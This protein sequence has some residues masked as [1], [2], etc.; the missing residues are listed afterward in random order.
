MNAEARA[1]I[2]LISLRFLITFNTL[3]AETVHINVYKYA[4]IYFSL[5]KHF[6]EIVRNKY[7]NEH[8]YTC[9][10]YKN[11]YIFIVLS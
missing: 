7:K 11:K 6:I 2:H 8:T 3:K 4:N 5:F 1:F 9:F 10:Q